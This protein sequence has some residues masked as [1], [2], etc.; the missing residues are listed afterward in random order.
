MTKYRGYY[1]RILI[2]G[3]SY[4]TELCVN[5]LSHNYNL[6]GYVPC[7]NTPVFGK[8]RLPEV[9]I[10]TE[11]DIKLS[12]QYDQ[13]VE[14]TSNAY[15]V[16]TGLLPEY[17]GRD[18]L[19]H[20]VKN[21]DTEQGLTFHKMT[22]EVDYGPIISKTTYPVFET[23]TSFDLYKRMLKVA[24]LFVENCLKLL[25]HLKDSQVEHCYKYPPRMYNRGDFELNDEFKEF[26]K[27][28][29]S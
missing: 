10:N 11:C 8:I 15:N 28:K 14:D 17:G 16:H 2:L 5:H 12:L 4:L 6:I 29:K 7:K 13:Y 25:S 27:C 21:G 20:T 24:P 18:I 1:T 9:D 23:D 22:N 26:I 3:S 19:D